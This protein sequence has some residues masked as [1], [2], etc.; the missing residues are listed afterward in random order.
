MFYNN[1]FLTCKTF[2]YNAALAMTG[3]IK[4]TSRE[5]LYHELGFVSLENRVKHNYFKNSSL[6]STVIE[7]NKLDLSICDSG[8][9]TNFKGT[10]LKC[11]YP[12]KNSVFLCNDPK[13]MQLLTRLRLRLSDL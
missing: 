8:S 11:I 5:K 9:L 4:E 10:I 13:G 12:S 3:T 7:R 1:T 6:S 2:Q